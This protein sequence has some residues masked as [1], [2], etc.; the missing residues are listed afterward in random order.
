MSSVKKQAVKGTI[1]TVVGYG[2]S[3]VLRFGSNLILT[4]LLDPELFGLMALVNTFIIG[5]NLFSDIG[6]RP[7][8][9]RSSRWQD[10]DFL[11]TAWT[12]QALRGFGVWIGCLIVAWPV[13]HF[14]NDFRLLWLVPIVGFTS[15][16]AG[17]YSTS[18]ATLERKLEIRKR[19]IYEVG[20]QTISTGVMIV[21]AY[22]RQTIWALVGGNLISNIVRLIWSHQLEPDTHN[23]FA[24]D[25]KAID[26]LISFGKWIFVSTAMTFLASQADRLILGKLLGLEILGVYTIAYTLSD[27]PR[28]MIQRVSAQI[29]FPLISRYIELDRPTLRDKI[30][31]KRWFLLIGLA[32]LV[33]G[34][35]SFGD[36]LIEFLYDSRYNQAAWMLPILAIGLWPLLL[37]FTINKALF[38]I[39]KP[40]YSAAGNFLKFFYMITALPLAYSMFGVFGA[41]LAVAFNDILPYC[42][43]NIGLWREGLSGLMQDIQATF[44]LI[45]LLTLVIGIRYS[46]GFG[47]PIDSLF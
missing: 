23:R 20:S 29:M 11:N 13:A 26:E 47:L 32:V 7:S 25:K 5:L 21:W 6:I 12:L 14:Y 36:L 24:W 33:T 9:I 2:G 28:Q 41:V 44:I 18:L 30:L 22:L 35:T 42:V 10:P 38:A 4:R 40:L 27:I 15:V 3:Q 16:I 37:S 8:I 17:F 43:V 34:L 46:L 1:W 19:T 31:K 39:G 45:G